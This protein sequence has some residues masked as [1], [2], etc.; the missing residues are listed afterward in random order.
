MRFPLQVVAKSRIPEDHLKYYRWVRFIKG[1][2]HPL[3][4]DTS[5]V[6]KVTIGYRTRWFLAMMDLVPTFVWRRLPVRWQTAHLFGDM[7]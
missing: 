3:D 1:K 7:E 6:Y 5:P 4:W 2:A